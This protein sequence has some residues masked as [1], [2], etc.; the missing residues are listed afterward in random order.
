MYS[1]GG[2]GGGLAPERDG[3]LYGLVAHGADVLAE[4]AAQNLSGNFSQVTRVLLT[5]LD[6]NNAARASYVLDG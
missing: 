6:T 2:G 3:I 4:F 5:R 1:G